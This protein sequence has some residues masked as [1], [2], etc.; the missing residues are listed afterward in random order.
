MFDHYIIIYTL[1][2]QVISKGK[3]NKADWIKQ[4]KF[5]T[6]GIIHE[7]A[8]DQADILSALYLGRGV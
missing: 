2:G 4:M 6:V 3:Q 5:K 8:V 1:K 7:V